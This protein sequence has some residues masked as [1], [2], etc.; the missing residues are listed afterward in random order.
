MREGYDRLWRWFGLSHASWLTIPRIMMHEM[1]DEWQDKMAELME[2]WDETWD[3]GE[4]PYPSV[5]AKGH[6]NKFTRWPSWLL[7]YRRPDK[8]EINKLKAKH[9][10]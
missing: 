3:S 4:M 7:N 2:E 10:P 9:N 8:A 6:D 1:P 5:S